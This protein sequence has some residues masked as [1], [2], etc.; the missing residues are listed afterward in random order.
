MFLLVWDGFLWGDGDRLLG[1]GVP[2]CFSFSVVEL[3]YFETG[4]L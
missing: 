1:D 3:T 4:G 2:Y